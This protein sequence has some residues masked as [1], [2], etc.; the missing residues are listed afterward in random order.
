VG[1]VEKPRI[2]GKRHHIEKDKS[3]MLAPF[4]REV[5]EIVRSSAGRWTGN[6]GLGFG[7]TR[8]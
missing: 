1:A 8:A 7:R 2:V 3:A 5:G 4:Q 6:A